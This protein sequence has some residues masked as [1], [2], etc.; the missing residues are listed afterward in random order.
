MIMILQIITIEIADVFVFIDV[1]IANCCNTNI[2]RTNTAQ[3]FEL[4][5]HFNFDIKR[6]KKMPCQNALKFLYIL[7][8]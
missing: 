1:R 5:K 6:Q 7:S 3:Y 2:I 8:K 4:D